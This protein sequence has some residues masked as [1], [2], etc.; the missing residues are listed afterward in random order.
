MFFI[1]FFYYFCRWKKFMRKWMNDFLLLCLIVWRFVWLVNWSTGCVFTT[2]KTH[3]FHPVIGT[4]SSWRGY[5]FWGEKWLSNLLLKLCL[6][7]D[8][9]RLFLSSETLTSV[10]TQWFGKSCLKPCL[11]CWTKMFCHSRSTSISNSSFSSYYS[12]NTFWDKV[13]FLA[14]FCADPY[15]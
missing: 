5:L 11:K 8:L 4:D 15:L 6:K 13:V 10:T 3:D 2:Q 1:Y 14:D 12:L 7:Y 9:K